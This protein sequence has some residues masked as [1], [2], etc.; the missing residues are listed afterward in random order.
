VGHPARGGELPLLFSFILLKLLDWHL[1]QAPSTIFQWC[2]FALWESR[3]EQSSQLVHSRAVDHPA[4]T[5]EQG[6]CVPP[7]QESGVYKEGI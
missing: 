2:T 1:G 3:L 7:G 6:L 4:Q 5:R